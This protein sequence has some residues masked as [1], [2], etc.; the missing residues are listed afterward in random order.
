[1][2][3]YDLED[4]AKW[5]RQAAEV[6]ALLEKK[7]N[8][9]PKRAKSPPGPVSAIGGTLKRTSVN[10]SK[11]MTRQESSKSEPDRCG[12]A[13]LCSALCLN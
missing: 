11:Y 8:A 9:S 3:S 1:M 5:E 13:V 7:R 6:Q 12:R 10:Q 4:D 2:H